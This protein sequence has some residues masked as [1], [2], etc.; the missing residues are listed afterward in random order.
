MI[1]LKH[2]NRCEPQKASAQDSEVPKDG[3]TFIYKA[4]L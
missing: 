2:T 1:V 3:V 4:H